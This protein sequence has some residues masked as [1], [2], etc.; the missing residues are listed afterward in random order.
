MS[1]LINLDTDE[2]L[3]WSTGLERISAAKSVIAEWGRTGRCGGGRE[4]CRELAALR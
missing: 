1:P 2:P 4:G 3:R